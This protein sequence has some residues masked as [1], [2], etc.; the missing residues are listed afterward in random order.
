MQSTILEKKTDY[1]MTINYSTAEKN[2]HQ[3]IITIEHYRCI[4]IHIDTHTHI[5]HKTYLTHT[6]HV[7]THTKMYY[8]Y[9]FIN[10]NTQAY[11]HIHTYVIEFLC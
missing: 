7:H 6:T 4:Y 1:M 9:I 3:I 11:T 10:S 5:S 2:D 8:E